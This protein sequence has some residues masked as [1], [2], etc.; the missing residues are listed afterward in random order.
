MKRI[1]VL[2]SG[3]G[4]NLQALIDACERG[5]IEGEIVAVVCDRKAAYGLTR[6]AEA[7]IETRHVSAMPFKGLPA[8]RES[9]DEALA[10]AV[11]PFEPDVVVLAGFMR[12]LTPVFLNAF[13]EK[14]VN[15]HPAL[16]GVFPGLRAIERAYES[17][18]AGQLS[19]TGVMVH[20]VIPELD[21]GPTLGTLTLSF[22]EGESLDDFKVRLQRAEH[23]LLVSVVAS[24]CD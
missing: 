2:V 16:P 6:A 21:A 12:I 23:R 11:S 5:S 1:V 8:A 22:R 20:R 9:Y 24:L 3:R 18:E 13:P 17:W 4:S 15:L 10:A 7:G 19:E 14:I